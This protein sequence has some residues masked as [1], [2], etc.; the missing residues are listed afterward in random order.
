ME[1][2]VNTVMFVVLALVLAVWAV[3]GFL[4]WIPLL[5]R[6]TVV[7]SASVVHAAIT[8]Q[9][10]TSM[11]E[12]LKDASRFWFQGFLIAKHALYPPKGQP[13]SWKI[14][15]R[16]GRILAGSLW[17][18]AFWLAVVCLFNLQTA[19]RVVPALGRRIR[20]AAIAFAAWANGL[21]HDKVVLTLIAAFALGV[22]A[23]AALMSLVK[24]SKAHKYEKANWE[25]FE[26][27]KELRERV[28]ALEKVMQ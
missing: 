5:T 7:F 19:R 14:K 8:G 16:M 2:L 21:Q 3:V 20:E 13:P 25:L 17:T 28:A 12:Y 10:S 1:L 4:F 23:G 22:V 18:A 27:N 15:I 6:A 26:D 11:R 9:H 24:G